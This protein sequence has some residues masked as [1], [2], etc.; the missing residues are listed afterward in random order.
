MQRQPPSAIGDKGAHSSGAAEITVVSRRHYPVGSGRFSTVDAWDAEVGACTQ[1]WRILVLV[2]LLDHTRTP[3]DQGIVRGPRGPVIV[4]NGTA[5]QLAQMG[6]HLVSIHAADGGIY[7]F[8]RQPNRAEQ[9]AEREERHALRRPLRAGSLR[10]RMRPGEPFSN[11][12]VHVGGRQHGGC[13]GWVDPD[14]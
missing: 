4:D 10:Y 1:A 7:E 5:Q 11:E 12:C 9:F 13:R 3:I 2:H 8:P 6:S 14:P